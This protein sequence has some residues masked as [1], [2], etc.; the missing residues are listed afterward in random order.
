M[1]QFIK[2]TSPFPNM[3]SHQS[4][5]PDLL[6]SFL[7]KAGEYIKESSDSLFDIKNPNSNTCLFAGDFSQLS[8]DADYLTLMPPIIRCDISSAVPSRQAEFIAGRYCA[9]KSL[10]AHGGINNLVVLREKDRSPKWPANTLGSIS[11]TGKLAVALTGHT[12]NTKAI[13]IDIEGIMK[14]KQAEKISDIVF[15]GQQPFDLNLGFELQTTLLF[16]AKETL[17][18]ALYPIHKKFME[19]SHA[20]CVDWDLNSG[21]CRLQ[22]KDSFI[23]PQ[24][25]FDIEFSFNEKHVLTKLII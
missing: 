24:R 4:D 8:I 16:S 10:M 9:A 15:S 18:K 19:F 2:P 23:F 14:V 20:N 13:G 21:L 7:E 17:F 12:N 1:N 25:Y 11:H 22:V 6:P 3:Q 5:N